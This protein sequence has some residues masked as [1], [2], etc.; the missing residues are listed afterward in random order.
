MFVR[1][2]VVSLIAAISLLALP[3]LLPQ[4]AQAQGT[5]E[6]KGACV[7][8]SVVEGSND[9]QDVATIQGL[10]CL[11]ANALTVFIAL[12]GLA[13]F[14]MIII[15]S[16]RYMLSGGNT[17][18]TE[19]SRSTI[20]YAI[21]GIIVALSAFIILRLLSAFTGVD[22]TT[23]SIPRDTDSSSSSPSGCTAGSTVCVGGNL[24]SC[25]ADGSTQMMIP[26]VSC[27]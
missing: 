25:Q 1:K 7:G 16:F 19:Q 21:I 24:H 4:T 11:I 8:G 14:V 20:T 2:L 26:P 15:A 27:P 12:I 5:L 17:K 22:L 10:E 18:G 6:W 3:L 13:A 9:K 23:F